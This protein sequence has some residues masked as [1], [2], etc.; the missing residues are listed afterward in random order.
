[1][2]AGGSRFPRPRFY[3]TDLTSPP[4]S[5]PNGQSR[6]SRRVKKGPSHSSYAQSVR[7][8][9]AGQGRGSYISLLLGSFARREER[10]KKW[11]EGLLPLP[12]LL[13]LLL[14][15]AAP[16]VINVPGSRAHAGIRPRRALLSVRPESRSRPAVKNE[17]RGKKSESAEKERANEFLIIDKNVR[18]RRAGRKLRPR[19]D[20]GSAIYSTHFLTPRRRP[21]IFLR[22][23]PGPE[24][25]KF[26][27]LVSARRANFAV[28]RVAVDSRMAG[29][30]GGRATLAAPST[31]PSAAP[32]STPRRSHRFRHL[33]VHDDKN[34][35]KRTRTCIGRLISIA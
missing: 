17:T 27:C 12:L 8:V 6:G 19:V 26:I 29:G 31:S 32:H 15:L 2:V 24:L 18:T 23:V 22:S 16:D 9:R 1:V 20:K 25:S 30:M 13:F 33:P 21:R 10:R 14:L 7:G 11:D 5:P 3:A 35:A 28:A 34:I 4:S